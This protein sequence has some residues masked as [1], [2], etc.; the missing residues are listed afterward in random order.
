[1]AAWSSLLPDVGK[2][3]EGIGKRGFCL[4]MDVVKALKGVGMQC[5]RG[6]C[7]SSDVGKSLKGVGM[8]CGRGFC[9]NVE[10][11]Q[12]LIGVGMQCHEEWRRGRI[13]G[14][15]ER[16]ETEK[17]RYKTKNVT[18]KLVYWL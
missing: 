1:M 4:R 16:K 13:R 11:G 17:K 15:E 18:G 5:S 6:F 12:A 9:Q 3:L 10:V 8:Q 14:R 7:L 2:A